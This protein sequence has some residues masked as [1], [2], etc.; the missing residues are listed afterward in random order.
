MSELFLDFIS[1][2]FC[3]LNS[4]CLGLAAYFVIF[5][6]KKLKEEDI[7]YFLFWFFGFLMFFVMAVAL[8]LASTNQNLSHFLVYIYLYLM[9]IHAVFLLLYLIKKTIKNHFINLITRIL[10]GVILAFY[11]FYFTPNTKLILERPLG[12]HFEF[13]GGKI[14]IFFSSIIVAIASFL[15][16]LVI[17]DQFKKGMA[18]FED[19]SG[20]YSDYAI[21]IY[22]L[23]TLPKSL[24]TLPVTWFLDI[25]FL[26]I[27][28]LVHLKYH[29][30]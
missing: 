25:F 3:F 15:M 24:Y 11:I 13:P 22:L 19:L 1:F 18:S 17:I 5:S 30:S 14:M 9:G 27:P 2:F 4:V 21:L 6:K 26:L 20:F 12:Y 8:G 10:I 7:L 23:M 16:I 28:Y 29:R